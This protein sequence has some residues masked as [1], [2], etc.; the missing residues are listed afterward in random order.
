MGADLEKRKTIRPKANSPTVRL[1]TIFTR[2]P[3]EDEA[4]ETPPEV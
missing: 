2:A 4:G 3:L 1:K